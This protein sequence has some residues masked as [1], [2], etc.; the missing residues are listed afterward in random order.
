MVA[1]MGVQAVAEPPITDVRSLLN[2]RS[3]ELGDA[4][5]RQKETELELS[6]RLRLLRSFLA[7]SQTVWS[8]A[9]GEV[10]NKAAEHAI[11]SRAEDM[12][13]ICTEIGRAESQ[14]E[15]TCETVALMQQQLET[16]ESLLDALTGTDPSEVPTVELKG[17]RYTK[18]LRQLNELA[19]MDHDS[20]ASRIVE[21][22]VQD[23]VESTANLE[24]IEQQVSL[25]RLPDRKE[26]RSCRSSLNSASKAMRNQLSMLRA[27]HTMEQCVRMLRTTLDQLGEGAARLDVIGDI[28]LVPDSMALPILRI[29]QV[30]V[31]NVIDHANAEQLDVTLSVTPRGVTL[32]VRDDGDGFDAVATE[33]RLGKTGGVG[34]LAM[35]ER[36][37]LAGGTL[38]IRSAV[39]VG[40]EVRAV[41]PM[42]AESVA[43]TQKT[44]GRA[45]R[46]AVQ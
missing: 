45:V 43:P 16:L 37:E 18:A 35:R 31:R 46:G 9:L 23:L 26:L 17:T 15:S 27:P 40:T 38:D 30:A 34:I 13:H 24:V 7:R 42:S 39:D 32:V 10:G 5:H 25:G 2:G 12:L 22:P 6:K 41:F 20:I 28:K 33:T 4:L 19:R 21:G 36:A 1:E 8:G 11:K 14:L 3:K 29:T 44:P